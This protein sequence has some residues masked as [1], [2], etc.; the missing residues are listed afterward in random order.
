MK[1]EY[2]NGL[3]AW[4]PSDKTKSFIATRLSIVPDKFIEWLEANKK[5]VDKKGY[6]AIDIMMGK[7]GKYYPKHNT[8]NADV[9]TGKSLN[10]WTA[11]K[12]IKDE[13]IPF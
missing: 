8:Y 9:I 1:Q 2:I 7:D 10:E 6:M 11:D 4:G 13:D 12:E 3:F 5:K